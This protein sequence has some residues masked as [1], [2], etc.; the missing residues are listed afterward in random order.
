MGRQHRRLRHGISW[1]DRAGLH[2][3]SNPS[4]EIELLARDAYSPLIADG[5]II[6]VLDP[7]GPENQSLAKVSLTDHEVVG[8][9]FE[10]VLNI[11]A[12][13]VDDDAVYWA[14]N[15]REG[16]TVTLWRSERQPGETVMLGTANGISANFLFL[17]DDW[18][19]F[20]ITPGLNADTVQLFRLPKNGG[21]PAEPIGDP[22]AT[23][24]F[25]SGD[26]NGL[27]GLITSGAGPLDPRANDRVVRIDPADGSVATLFETRT[28]QNV[29][30]DADY[31]YWTADD[32]FKEGVGTAALWR[33][34]RDG[35][36]EPIQLAEGYPSGA[37]GLA[38][39]DDWIYFNAGNCDPTESNVLRMAKPEPL[40]GDSFN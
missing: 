1:T 34:R 25:F 19:Y 38:V 17:V 29:A 2:F 9:E 32:S 23:F 18:L 36:G 5:E 27:F 40:A 30:H 7:M 39:S 21:E 6:F 35:E 13:T 12:F 20:W 4:A 3:Q 10:S 22:I 37:A 28:A 31:V 33:G 11:T 26:A 16:V 14:S 15:D 8:L 24:F